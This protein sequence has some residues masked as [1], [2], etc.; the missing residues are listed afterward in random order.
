MARP[1][2]TVEE[3]ELVRRHIL[4][5]ARSDARIIAGA[6]I[7]SD[8]QGN[9]DRWS[10]LDLTF[11]LADRANLNEVLDDWTNDIKSGYGAVHLFDVSSHTTVY[12][13]FLLPGNLQ[14]DLSFTPG[15]VAEYG[16]RFKLLFGNAVKREYSP[17][18]SAREIF[19]M[20]VHHAVRARYCLERDR[21]WQAEYWISGVRD[22]ALVL[23]C[24]RLGLEGYHGRGFDQ[25]P[26]DTRERASTALV[27]ST[28]R[29][30]LLR[31]LGKSVDLLVREAE[32]VRSFAAQLEP[33][34]RDLISL[35][36]VGGS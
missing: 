25:L 30:E 35:E 34:L 12:R 29:S 1:P 13:V 23:A 28:D 10:D 27:R 6:S 5:K 16:P 31:A 14:V 8:A 36:W 9:S 21:V 26:A 33:Q 19:G 11:G 17:P 20:G 22:Q 18:S 2:F 32:E 7:G 24:R 15:F 3:R 4:Q